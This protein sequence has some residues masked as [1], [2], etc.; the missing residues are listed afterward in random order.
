M[1]SDFVE[2][3]GRNERNEQL[4]LIV[5][6]L[7]E[8]DTAPADERQYTAYARQANLVSDLKYVVGMLRRMRHDCAST[9]YER[10]FTVVETELRRN[11]K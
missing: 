10:A 9:C 6:R 4:A 3:N 5:Q 8:F 11:D 2:W 1:T 7:K